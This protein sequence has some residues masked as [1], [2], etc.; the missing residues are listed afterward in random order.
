M[1]KIALI[2]AA[3]LAQV[4]VIGLAMVAEEEAASHKRLKA[5]MLPPGPAGTG[6]GI[7]ALCVA[8]LALWFAYAAGAE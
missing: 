8:A 7:G 3:V 2:V 1:V 5:A 6:L 4:V